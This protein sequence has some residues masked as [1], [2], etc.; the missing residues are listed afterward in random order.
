M[1]TRGDLD[2]ALRR[3]EAGRVVVVTGA[4]ISAESGIP[5]FRGPEGYWTVGSRE[6]HP[7]ELATLSAFRTMPGEIWRWYLHRLDVCRAARPNPGHEALVEL[8][9]RLGDRFLLA[10]QNVDGLHLRAG[11]TASRTCQIHG[12][13]EFRRCLGDCGSPLLPLPEDLGALRDEAGSRAELID[14]LRCPCG[15]PTRP[16]VLWFDE[17]YDETLYR[18]ETAMTAASRCDLLVVIGTSGSASLPH[19]IALA[20]VGNGAAIID[21]NPE[22]SPFRDLAL[23]LPDG[24]YVDEP[25]GIALPRLVERL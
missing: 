9:R 1:G 10:T 12:N 5:T 15:S 24:A 25:A 23:R 14:R 17:Y 21:I 6:Y 2:A 3:G 18:S 7:Q 20:A 4:G 22:A 16:H 13:I 8:E 11:Q 19:R